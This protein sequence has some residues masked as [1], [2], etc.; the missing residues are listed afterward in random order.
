MRKSLPLIF[1]QNRLH[2][3][4]RA[5]Y[6]AA[7]IVLAN[8]GLNTT[9]PCLAGATEADA[10]GGDLVTPRTAHTATLLSDGRVL[11]AGGADVNGSALNSAEL[12]DPT[13]NTW[14]ATGSLNDARFFHGAARLSDGRVLMVGGQIPHNFDVLTAEIYDPTTGDWT[15][16][17]S[18]SVAHTEFDS[19]LLPN[20]KVLVAS[21]LSNGFWLALYFWSG[22]GAAPGIR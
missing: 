13:T 10:F 20:G 17:A 1:S 15:Y 14:A 3:P 8:F 22:R 2:T 21:G 5:G 11:L 9:Q 12:Y 4:C 19:V 7:L 6:L 16:T 18:P